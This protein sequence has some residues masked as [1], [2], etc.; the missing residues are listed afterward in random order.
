MIRRHP[1]FF[2]LMIAFQSVPLTALADQAP[3]KP[4]MGPV[5]L[6][7]KAFEAQSDGHLAPGDIDL[8]FEDAKLLIRGLQVSQVGNTI[9]LFGLIPKAAVNKSDNDKGSGDNT[10]RFQ[11]RNTS[12]GATDGKV[13]FRITINS[14]TR[15]IL[16]NNPCTA[17]NQDCLGLNSAFNGQS[18]FSLTKEHKEGQIWLVHQDPNAEVGSPGSLHTSSTSVRFENTEW[19]KEKEKNRLQAERDAKISALNHSVQHCRGSLSE[20]KTA[21]EALEELRLENAVSDVEKIARELD[22]QEFKLVE[23]GA[24]TAQPA[25]IDALRERVAAWAASHK[26]EAEQDRAAN[27]LLGMAQSLTRAG[28]EKNSSQVV[29]QM[30]SLMDQT[31]RLGVSASMRSKLETLDRK[32]ALV[33]MEEQAKSGGWASNMVLQKSVEAEV[34]SLYKDVLASCYN[35]HQDRI[36]GLTFVERNQAI[37]SQEQLARQMERCQNSSQELQRVVQI[38]NTAMLVDSV[39][40]MPMGAT[41]PGMNMGQGMNPGMNMGQGMSPGMNMGQGMNPGMNMGQGMN[42]NFGT[43]IGGFRT[44]ARSNGVGGMF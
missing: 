30:Q 33:S 35:L 15:E 43:G 9:Q 40:Q 31:K 10:V 39:P 3:V 23:R 32:L 11:I 28:N 29:S 16:E 37:T 19:T 34:S 1:I 7:E 14:N 21:R 38:R 13:G 26:S 6:A 42:Q 18:R 41:P 22:A 24:T 44:G 27:V 25:E 36:I 17:T 20:I 2:A 5:S 4:L 8:S 12:Q